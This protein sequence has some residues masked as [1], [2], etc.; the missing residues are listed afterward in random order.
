MKM[1]AGIVWNDEKPWVIDSIRYRDG[2]G[3]TTR[4]ENGDP[5]ILTV[6]HAKMTPAMRTEVEGRGWLKTWDS[7]VLRWLR[8]DMEKDKNL[9]CPQNK[10]LE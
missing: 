9:Y 5:F 10:S 1:K 8:P 2:T 7:T 4:G 6:D 3:R